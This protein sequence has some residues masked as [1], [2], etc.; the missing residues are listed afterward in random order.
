MVAIM[1]GLE[2][3]TYDRQYTDAYLFKR[4]FSY[5]AVYR[6]Q[7]IIVVLAFSVLA[8]MMA[9][10]P[11]LIAEG[12]GALEDPDGSNT[13][14][15]VLIALFIA[16][17][18]EYITNWLRRRLLTRVIGHVIAQMRN[19]AFAAAVERDL[20]FYDENN[21]GKIVSRITSDTQEFGDIVLVSSD[22][23][24]RLLQVFVL[25]AIMLL[26]PDYL[27]DNLSWVATGLFTYAVNAGV[28]LGKFQKMPSYHTRLAKTSWAAMAVAIVAAFVDWGDWP[29]QVA[30][31][32]VL[33]TNIEQTAMTL[34]LP[35][36]AVDLSCFPK[37]WS[38]R[39]ENRA[40]GRGAPLKP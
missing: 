31:S 26:N 12:V 16:A 24:A 21:T 34:V 36:Y 35:H 23:I 3:D 2:A 29:L 6:Q 17:F 13:I 15:L 28:C 38:I 5:F 7:L 9:F 37:A 20:A 30:A 19:D 11:L 4:I 1:S 18:L 25:I 39:Q 33:A 32:F 27:L 22:I 8:V 10:Q 14:Q 40:N